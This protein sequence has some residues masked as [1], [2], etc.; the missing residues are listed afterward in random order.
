M[1]VME[2]GAAVGIVHDVW[3]TG[4]HDLLVVAS[5]DRAERLLPMVREFVI[6]IDR[7][8]RRVTVRPPGGWFDDA[9]V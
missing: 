3:P 2:S 9:A 7:A 5:G 4:P 8:M 1:V 6:H